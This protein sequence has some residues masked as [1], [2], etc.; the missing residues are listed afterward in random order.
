M[1]Q[2]KALLPFHGTPLIVHA[3]D[4]LRSLGLHPVIAGARADLARYAPVI[5]DLHPG[6]GPLGGVE[7]ALSTADSPEEPVLFLPVDLPLLPEA[8]LTVMME[9][10]R[11]S[12]ALATIPVFSGRAQ[13]LCAI[14]RAKLLPGITAALE[15]GDYK[16][17]CVMSGLTS[18][19]TRDLF[20]VEAAFTARSA[21]LDQTRQPLHRWFHNLNTAQDL[22]WAETLV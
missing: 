10:A 8:F 11:R 14:Y 1:G 6:C 15:S 5:A 12:G 3:L 20:Q 19:S 9:R 7:A 16:V 4:R 21:L 13:P 18:C 17:L 22:A 2:D